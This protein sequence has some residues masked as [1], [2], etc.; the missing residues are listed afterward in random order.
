MPRVMCSECRRP[1]PYCV[2]GHI[3]PVCNVTRV[4]ILQHPDEQRHPFNTARLA[5]L[6]LHNCEI[7]VNEV[8]PDL[9]RELEKT[10]S[11]Y[12][13][14]PGA[15]AQTPQMLAEH[16]ATKPTLLIVPD[17]TWRKASKILYANP[18]LESLPRVTLGPGNP[19]RYRIRKAPKPEAVATIEAIVRTLEVWEPA[20]DF[21]LVLKPFEVMVEQQL[22]AY[23]V[24]NR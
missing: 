9:A 16:V 14:F 17:G 4:L 7:W 8:F 18:E 24:E 10:S 12:L 1:E 2:C 19:S 15:S 11:A 22:A 20:N 13:L 6:G 5:A 21:S 3:T 23:S